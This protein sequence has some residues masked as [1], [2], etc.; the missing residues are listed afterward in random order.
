MKMRNHKFIVLAGAVLLMTVSALFAANDKKVTPLKGKPVNA[1]QNQIK[2]QPKKD[3]SG[4][5][6]NQSSF[7]NPVAGEEINWQ[8]I[9]SGGDIDGS[10]TNFLLSGTVGQTAVGVGSSDNFGL[11]HG[12]WQEL[13][14][15]CDCIPGDANGDGEVNIGDAVYL[16]AYVF[17]G[18]PPPTPYPL[19]SGDANC[20]C[21]VNIGDAVYII[22]YV[23]KGG[24]PPC[25]CE[26]W[27]DACG[28]P[29]R[30]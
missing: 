13:E 9:S 27:L 18:G 8:V 19:C 4:Q 20:D 30:K 25:S 15:V 6:V 29:L 1:V 28:P 10:S 14:G 5:P 22:A 2:L 16:I 23:F 17:K 24:P 26:E 12:F 21:E 11:S 7:A 3:V